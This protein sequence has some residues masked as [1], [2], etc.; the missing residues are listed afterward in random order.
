MIPDPS[1]YKTVTDL[2]ENTN[3]LL[4]SV[5]KMT[6]PFIIMQNNKPQAV[7]ISTHHYNHLLDMIEELEEEK[8]AASLEQEFNEKDYLS[9][10][11]TAKLLGVEL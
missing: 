8:F 1:Q 4:K 10:D 6:N 7:M 11:E 2:R 3:A 5:K 9:E